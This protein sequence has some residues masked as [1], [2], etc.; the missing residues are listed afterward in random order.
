MI[1]FRFIQARIERLDQLIAGLASEVHR[2]R[3]GDR[4]AAHPHVPMELLAYATHL[5]D[6]ARYLARGREALGRARTALT[7]SHA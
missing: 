7:T 1:D 6:A 2:M 5:E 4:R 3:T